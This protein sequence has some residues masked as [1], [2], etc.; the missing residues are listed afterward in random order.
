MVIFSLVSLG[1]E[2]WEYKSWG[3][4][5]SQ[6]FSVC[7]CTRLWEPNGCHLQEFHCAHLKKSSQLG[8]LTVDLPSL[9]GW[10]GL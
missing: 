3:F 7:C 2:A 5:T 9:E 8:L 4:T 1:E 10:G 6:V